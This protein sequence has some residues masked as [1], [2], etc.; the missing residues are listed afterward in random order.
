VRERALTL[1]RGSK[2]PQ[3]ENVGCG[4]KWLEYEHFFLEYLGIARGWILY[5][6]VYFCIAPFP[7]S[8]QNPKASN[9]GTNC[10]DAK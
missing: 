1:H 9:K 2:G 8:G 10:H 3:P 6:C 4:R 7:V 5:A